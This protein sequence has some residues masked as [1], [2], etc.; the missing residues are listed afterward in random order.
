MRISTE[1]LQQHL[2]RELKPLYAVFGGETLLALE[3]ADRIRARAR[4]DG[5]TERTVLSVDSGFRWSE[6][7]FAGSAQSLFATRKL[8]ELRIPS[9]KPG[10]TGSEAVQVYCESPA[11]DT[12]TLV[13][14]PGLDWRAQKAGWFEA[15]DRAGVVIEAKPVTRKALPDWLAGR[16]SAQNQEADRETLELIA[17]RVE[18]NLL[19]AHQEIQK[20]ALL[21][22]AG[23]IAPE[24]ARAAIID[25]ARFDVFNLGE[26]MLE[27]DILHL[28]RMLDA[29]RSEGV[30]PPLVLWAVSEEIRAIG[31]VLDG[32]QAGRTAPQLWREAKVWGNNHQQL[33]QRHCRRFTREQVEAAI[34]HAARADRLAK[35]LI[36]GDVWDEL[37]QLALRF[38]V[39]APASP[40]QK[41][42]KMPAGSRAAGLNQQALF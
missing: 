6:L 27:G 20:L 13:C 12:V 28:A 5:Y 24:E 10:V 26:A 18:G 15:L 8:L 35:G 1:Q 3:A 37:L 29:L 7:A 33:M 40:V 30:A 17:D 38:A 21:L 42:S 9:G 4:S 19:A 32:L 16:L 34:R 36:R 25:V 23:K 2:A 31:R 11:P 39:A 41:R 14:L 22:P